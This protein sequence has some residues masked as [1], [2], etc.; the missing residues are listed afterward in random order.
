MALFITYWTG[1]ARNNLIAGAVV[2]DETLAV[3]ASSAQS[4]VTPANADYLS[5]TGD[6][7]ARFVYGVDPTALVTSTFI[8]AGERLWMDA[9]PGYK[10][11]G[12]AG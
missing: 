2:S 7:N 6:D 3:S 9:R 8:N 11:A 10:V 1:S 4:A 5:I 12:I